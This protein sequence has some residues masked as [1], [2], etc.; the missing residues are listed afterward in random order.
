VFYV[1]VVFYK[2]REYTLSSKSYTQGHKSF[3]F[4]EQTLH[5]GWS[6]EKALYAKNCLR[7]RGRIS[8]I[9]NILTRRSQKS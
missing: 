4:C 5:K 9:V 7:A 8:R 2:F 1:R 6:I 3:S